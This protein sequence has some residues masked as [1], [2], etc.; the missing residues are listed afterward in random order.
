[1]GFYVYILK[2]KDGSYYTGH[3]D[4]MDK[5][6]YEHQHGLIKTCYTYKRRPVELVFV[7][8]LATRDDAFFAERQIKGW[9]RKK[10][11]ALMQEDWQE[12]K[13]LNSIQKSKNIPLNPSTSSG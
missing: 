7:D 6:L 2:C 10:K 3:T 4:D 11:E 9:S 8:M 12:I 5:R 13:R 1:M